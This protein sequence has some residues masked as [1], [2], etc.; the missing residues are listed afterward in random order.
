MKRAWV[1]WLA[2]LA[3]TLSAS[4]QAPSP[5]AY[6]PAWQMAPEAG[7][8]TANDQ[9]DDRQAVSG[10]KP[11][12]LETPRLANKYLTVSLQ[13]AQVIDNG[14]AFNSTDNNWQPMT[15][16][17]GKFDL[18]RSGRNEGTDIL[19]YGGAT[20]YNTNAELTS[21]FH[22]LDVEQR[23]N[24]RHWQLLVENNFA[25]YPQSPFG[26]TTFG[27][28][29]GQEGGYMET[30]N[31]LSSLYP[32]LPT[33]ELMLT[34]TGPRYSNTALGQ[35]EYL[36]TPRTSF[37]ISGAYGVLRFLDS[38]I[39]NSDMASVSAG[40][41]YRMTKTDEI[42]ANYTEGR[43]MFGMT[44]QRLVTHAV[45]FSYL[46]HVNSRML[47]EAMVGPQIN[48]YHDAFFNSSRELAWN[49]GAR[50]QY[51]FKRSE[52]SLQYSRL[53]TGGSG[54]LPGAATQLVFA[55]VTT[56]VTR[57]MWLSLGGG[58]SRNTALS[59]SYYAGDVAGSFNSVLAAASVTRT[60]RRSLDYYLRYSLQQQIAPGCSQPVCGA[61]T[62]QHTIEIGFNYNLRPIRLQ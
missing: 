53:V 5:A 38:Q 62:R 13:A 39:Q 55:D 27:L 16:L 24:L 58:Y 28:P 8:E 21:S 60:V 20:I 23:F 51:R 1:I 32:G 2:L 17:S 41:S 44:S 42:G 40:V 56:Q 7:Q 10:V 61:H 9:G 26:N 22:Q 46:H 11:I 57:K 35:V 37:T 59:N 34:D 25:F 19:Y 33:S 47:I 3:L 18:H 15:V 29:A 49:A 50:M 31:V 6:G 45:T 14:Y 43:M 12:R 52:V 4:S 30:L 54:I 48:Q 36:L